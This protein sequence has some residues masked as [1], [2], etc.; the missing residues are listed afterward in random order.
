MTRQQF[1]V[2][3]TPL[4]GPVAPVIR[5][6]S[7]LKL[8]LRLFGLRAVEVAE[9]GQ[10]APKMPQDASGAI[11]AARQSAGGLAQRTT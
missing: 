1:V 9:I 6:R 2:T 10:D 7:F 8:A 3:L 5:L 11:K 4:P